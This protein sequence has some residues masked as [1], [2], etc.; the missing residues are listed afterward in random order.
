M[1]A[2]IEKS[3]FRRG[4]YV[5]YAFGAWRIV[6]AEGGWRAIPPV[7]MHARFGRVLPITGATLDSISRRLKDW[8]TDQDRATA[9][10][11]NDCAT[12]GAL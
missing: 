7:N 1:Y 12:H 8:E 4:E 3:A 6:K 11:P 9:F 10:D 5:G 2:N